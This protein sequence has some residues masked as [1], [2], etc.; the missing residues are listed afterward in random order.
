M[1]TSAQK[2]L[3]RPLISALVLVPET[4]NAIVNCVNS[5]WCDKFCMEEIIHMRIKKKLH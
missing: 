1:H 5:I 4:Q 2:T 3:H